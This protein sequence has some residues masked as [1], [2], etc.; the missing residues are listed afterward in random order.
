MAKEISQPIT[1]KAD[2]SLVKTKNQL[3]EMRAKQDNQNIN[4]KTING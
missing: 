2:R 1:L 3:L 4:E